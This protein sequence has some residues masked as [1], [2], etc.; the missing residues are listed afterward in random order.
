MGGWAA[1]QARQTGCPLVSALLLPAHR[2]AQTPLVPCHLQV[3]M[4]MLITCGNLACESTM[5]GCQLPN[6]PA[7][8]P[9]VC[10]LRAS[11]AEKDVRGLPCATLIRGNT[12]A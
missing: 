9:E 5:Q 8:N 4:G 3:V 1:A 10:F 11:T 2:A 6:L 12:G 7:P